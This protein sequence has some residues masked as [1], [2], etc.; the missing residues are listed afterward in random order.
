MPLDVAYWSPGDD[1]TPIGM[2]L[3]PCADR[4]VWA[5]AQA[6]EILRGGSGALATGMPVRPF[7]EALLEAQLPHGGLTD[8]AVQRLARSQLSAWRAGWDRQR[9][10]PLLKPPAAGSQHHMLAAE[11]VEGAVGAG[12]LWLAC[13]AR[14]RQADP[15]LRTGM[16][17]M[18]GRGDVASRH[19]LAFLAFHP[20]DGAARTPA[21]ATW[22]LPALSLRP[23]PLT[24]L[25]G[26]GGVAAADGGPRPDLAGN[27]VAVVATGR[28]A[29]VLAT[30]GAGSPPLRVVLD[31]HDHLP[32]LAAAAI[33]GGGMITLVPPDGKVHSQTDAV[34]L[35]EQ[36]LD[37]KVTP[38]GDRTAVL[39][40]FHWVRSLETHNGDLLDFLQVRPHDPEAVPLYAAYLELVEDLPRITP[41]VEVETDDP[42]AE[43]YRQRASSSRMVFGLARHLAA[44]ADQF[45]AVWGVKPGKEVAWVFFDSAVIHWQLWLE[46]G[47]DITEFH[48]RLATCGRYHLSLLGSGT[49]LRE[50]LE[51]LLNAWL[52]PYGEP[53]FLALADAA[54]PALHLAIAG[55]APDAGLQILPATVSQLIHLWEK[56]G[57]R[58]ERTVALL[59]DA[60]PLASFWDD[61]AHNR[62]ETAW[63]GEPPRF[64]TTNRFWSGETGVGDLTACRL[65][66]PWLSSLAAEP[67][68]PARRSEIASWQAFDARQRARL[69][70]ERNLCSL[71]VNALLASGAA[72][73]DIADP[74]WWRRF[75]LAGSTVAGHPLDLEAAAGLAVDN[76]G[77][78]YDLPVSPS[79]GAG[80]DG[81]RSGEAPDTELIATTRAWLQQHELL[82]DDDLGRP[83]GYDA[84]AE[85]V[86]PRSS[87][88]DSVRLVIGDGT[89]AW[90][91]VASW[92]TGRRERG[93]LEDW[94]L[95]IGANPPPGAAE[96]AAAFPADGCSV[97]A[98]PDEAAIGAELPGIDHAPGALLW[99]TPE[100]YGDPAL[101]AMLKRR[102]P[103]V[104]FAS[105][106]RQWL[107]SA[108]MFSTVTASLFRWLIHSAIPRVVLHASMLSP[109]WETYLRDFWRRE[110]GDRGDVLS[111]IGAVARDRDQRAEAQP[112]ALGRL[113]ILKHVCPRCA[114]P[115]PL[116]FNQMSCPGCGLDSAAWLTE[117]GRQEL[118]RQL[119]QTKLDA[120]RSRQ[121]LGTAEVLQVWLNDD[122]L[123]AV[124]PLLEEFGMTARQAGEVLEVA[125]APDR[126]WRLAPASAMPP[127]LLDGNH[128]ILFPPSPDLVQVLQNAPDTAAISLWFH[129][130]ELG[131]VALPP[132]AER[133]NRSRRLLTTLE[134]QTGAEESADR[135]A[136]L[137]QEVVPLSYLSALCGLPARDVLQDLSVMRWLSVLAGE[138][139]TGSGIGA[140]AVTDPKVNLLV[141]WQ[142]VEI[143]YRTHRLAT[144][145][146][147]LLPMILASTR[148]GVPTLCDLSALPARIQEEYLVWLDRFLIATSLRLGGQLTSPVTGG[149]ESLG[150]SPAPDGVQILYRPVGGLL[151]SSRRLV[152]YLGS[153]GDVKSR[154][155]HHLDLFLAD[156]KL[157]LGQAEAT[158]DGFQVT[159]DAEWSALLDPSFREL[160]CLLGLW[161]W[162]GPAG[163][164]EFD[165]TSLVTL[166][167][168]GGVQAVPA[169]Q[170]PSAAT[171][172]A[173]FIRAL[174]CERD[175]WEAH[176]RHCLPLG[177]LAPRAK[178]DVGAGLA[179]VAAKPLTSSG[180]EAAQRLRERALSAEP[181]LL[182][183]RGSVGSGRLA[184]VAHGI[185]LARADGLPDH[186]VV[187]FCPD[188]GSAARVHWALRREVPDWQP[189]L[190]LAGAGGLPSGAAAT[191]DLTPNPAGEVAI[192]VE[193]QRFAPEQRYRVA[194][195]YQRRM[196][197]SIIDPGEVEEPWEHLFLTTP[198]PEE[199]IACEHQH[200]IG[201]Q[202]WGELRQLVLPGGSE[203]GKSKRRHKGGCRALWAANLDECV[204]ALEQAR[205]AGELGSRIALV[206]P[207]TDD[208]IYLGRRLAKRGWIPVFRQELDLLMMPG[209]C[210]FL[211]AVADATA[212]ECGETDSWLEPFLASHHRDLYASWRR[213]Q[214]ISP[215]ELL[216]DFYEMSCRAA[217]S[218]TFLTYPDARQRIE[219]IVEDFGSETLLRFQ[220]RP[221]WEAWRREIV[222]LFG[223][224]APEKE[225]A[226]V[227]LATSD[228]GGGR[229]SPTGAYLCLG[230]EPTRQHYGVMSRV[231]DNLLV[232]YQERSPLPSEAAQ[233]TE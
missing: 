101:R 104:V 1:P 37:G 28:P 62:I 91:E 3:A 153:I 199:I 74:R 68:E 144:A 47:A 154:L 64:F 176:L 60:G 178:P 145:L 186:G 230:S 163:R 61:L 191:T 195:H 135:S 215:E 27:R 160:G 192:L 180:Q 139:Q 204:V 57:D 50:Q 15:A 197:I 185:R 88:A 138:K 150:L 107:P 31:R 141:K 137:D 19:L 173:D 168:P 42:W 149:E 11:G 111:A 216:Q 96:L 225:R 151:F 127:A 222:S 21:Q 148:P 66:V 202:I 39:P 159:V 99:I 94:G 54:P 143:E 18:A 109:A 78:P 172:S 187:F 123:A 122:D 136:G 49:F 167:E 229:L 12:L 2:F 130:Q 33:S 165:L 9:G 210:E 73:V 147:T 124:E 106:C 220:K 97:W 52:Q 17:E 221:L 206:A 93:Y 203:W 146:D 140:T 46:L 205:T 87:A 40:L 89:Q 90:W 189:P 48:S 13:L 56:T 169:E 182:V 6:A 200:A 81:R 51:E 190:I 171:S 152:G 105:D 164:N 120:L 156:V 63:A 102:P 30:W 4:L 117:T 113:P 38:D 207:L 155:H 233:E 183:L 34:Q 116:K 20:Q 188:S 16:R 8:E 175:D 82:L 36:L 115:V 134:R 166:R 59:P 209:P 161:R 10:H 67:V 129:G 98:A 118:E 55:L 35:L 218:A 133:T 158:A 181:N 92:L 224:P 214:R 75:S 41:Q 162:T 29:S 212:G 231:T 79:R 69:A 211:A 72:E 114:D 108:S 174:A 26:V 177:L 58:G 125:P 23:D 119:L 53:Y 22:D 194:Q 184:A 83:P 132:P 179:I 70:L 223:L 232:L 208:L 43:Q 103:R 201:R 65:V 142:F 157:L 219:K 44:S 77:R 5:E 14:V 128:A 170:Q 198:K 76:A 80:K 85:E 24:A 25:P 86:P 193:A 84:T 121:D 226:L 112:V 217:W 228:T 45:D 126:W 131:T 32:L 110:L 71:E 196:L 7:A 95:V 227:T 213:E 100:A